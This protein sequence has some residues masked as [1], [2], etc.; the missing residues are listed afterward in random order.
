MKKERITVISKT[1]INRYIA[2]FTVVI[3]LLAGWLSVPIMQSQTADSSSGKAA[4]GSVVYAATK[5]GIIKD[6]PLNVRSGAGTKY[7]VLGT[8]AKKTVVTVICSVKDSHGGK[9]YKIKFRRK[10]GYVSAQYVILSS[11]NG[12]EYATAVNGYVKSS[13]YI[14][15]RAGIS[16]KKYGKYYAGNII[17]LRG[18]RKGSDGRLWYR[19]LYKSKRGYALAGKIMKIGY[20][21]YSPVKKGKT[22][23]DLLRVRQGPAVSFKK[24]GTLPNGKQI[25]LIGR[26]KYRGQYW[27]KIKFNSRAAYVSKAYVKLMSAEGTHSK[28]LNFESYMTKQGF[29]QSYKPYLRKLHKA[30]PKWVFKAQKTGLR[31]NTVVNAEGKLGN[32]LVEPTAPDSWKTLRQGAYN[33]VKN[34]YVSFD[35]RWKQASSGIIKYYLD[36]RNGLNESGIYEFLTHKYDARTQNLDTVKNITSSVSGCFMNTLSYRKAI[37]NAGIRSGVSPNVI[38]AMVIMEQGWQGSSL[39]S[40][41][42]SK[43]RG[44]YNHFNIGAYT[45][46]KMTAVQH[47]LWWAKGAG[48]KM[49]HKK[50]EYYRPWDTITNSLS[51]GALYYAERYVAL[52]QY[53][54]YTKKFNVMNGSSN[55]PKHEYSTAVF[56]AM[57]EGAILKK[58][59]RTNDEFALTFHIPVYKDMPATACKKPGTKGN[60]DYYLKSLKISGYSLLPSFDR[61]TSSYKMTVAKNVSSIK[62]TAAAHDRGATVMGTGNI[63]LQ[64]GANTVRI[65]VRATSGA[66][67]TYTI[68]ITRLS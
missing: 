25:A 29:P 66:A 59:Y 14:R 6:G 41:K 17:K 49:S 56:A 33:F 30:H 9:W 60:N 57:S 48:K 43:Y 15:A 3:L 4:G 53:T 8:I 39:V 36:P 20:V 54:Y 46:P 5:K 13:T 16:A 23:A 58:A 63:S 7:R 31:W 42:V 35:G 28:V 27:Y 68:K 65:K 24:L 61:Y 10:S 62:V 40:G 52:N 34:A 19:V 67:K 22:K 37:N 50:S 18:V 44:I 2:V 64:T 26:V 51:G 55:L 47:G 11:V 38:T 1:R 32:N 21:K 12:T 45:T